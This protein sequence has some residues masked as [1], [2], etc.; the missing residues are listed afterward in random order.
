MG[1]NRNIYLNNAKLSYRIA[2]YILNGHIFHTNIWRRKQNSQKKIGRNV[3]RIQVTSLVWQIATKQFQKT[4]PKTET[5]NV[6]NNLLPLNISYQTSN[7]LTSKYSRPSL[8]T[9]IL[10]A[11]SLIHVYKIGWEWQFSSQNL[12]FV[13]RKFSICSTVWWNVSTANNMENL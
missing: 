4:I 7:H 6:R 13:M 8:F 12:T 10:S 2:S 1:V 11:K 9:D 3:F 5:R